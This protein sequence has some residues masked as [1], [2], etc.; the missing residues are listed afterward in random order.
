MNN[1]AKIAKSNSIDGPILVQMYRLLKYLP[2][3]PEGRFCSMDLY[4]SIKFSINLS[5]VKFDN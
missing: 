3:T 2:F 1:Y 5:F 4:K